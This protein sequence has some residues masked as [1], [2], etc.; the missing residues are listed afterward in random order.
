MSHGHIRDAIRRYS[1]GYI[2]VCGVTDYIFAPLGWRSWENRSVNLGNKSRFDGPNVRKEFCYSP[3]V[4]LVFAFFS[5]IMTVVVLFAGLLFVYDTIVL[6]WFGEYKPPGVRRLMFDVI[7]ICIWVGTVAAGVLQSS[8]LV[9]L[10][11]DRS[12]IIILNE[13][14]IIMARHDNALIRWRDI[15]AVDRHFDDDEKIC[16]LTL[17]SANLVDIR[18][19]GLV[20]ASSRK[21]LRRGVHRYIEEY[22]RRYR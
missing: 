17:A 8:G 14:G 6:G 9:T 15:R 18:T 20:D 1:A 10:S 5:L 12:P 19:T 7:G 21:F 22:W 3:T 4:H 2:T 13:I 16:R 11:R